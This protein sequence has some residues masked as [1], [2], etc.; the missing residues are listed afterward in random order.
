MCNKTCTDSTF[1]DSPAATRNL[2]SAGQPLQPL[3]HELLGPGFKTFAQSFLWPLRG[4]WTRLPLT[5]L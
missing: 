4:H 5:I 3:G 2:F 1:A